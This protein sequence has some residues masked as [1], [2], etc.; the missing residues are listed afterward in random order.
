MCPWYDVQSPT[1]KVE[2]ISTLTHI[3]LRW[4]MSNNN[5]TVYCCSPLESVTC[6][7]KADGISCPPFSYLLQ[8]TRS[9]TSYS[10]PLFLCGV[11]LHCISLFYAFLPSHSPPPSL[12]PFSPP[13]HKKNTLKWDFQ[14]LSGQ[15]VQSVLSINCITVH[16]ICIYK[17]ILY[18]IYI[19]YF[20]CKYELIIKYC[21]TQ[22]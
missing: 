6:I 7:I 3:M 13:T 10:S 20:I 17:R 1:E 21:S 4:N 22:T 8:C 11:R 15:T 14:I 19:L 16:T 2:T 12:L 18:S 5:H 9:Y